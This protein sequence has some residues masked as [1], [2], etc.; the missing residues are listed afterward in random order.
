M[1]TRA[2]AS[3]KLTPSKAKARAKA[4]TPARTKKTAKTKAKAKAPGKPSAPA[5][6]KATKATSAPA[7]RQTTTKAP[8]KAKA[9]ASPAK[10][11]PVAIAAAPTIAPKSVSKAKPTATAAK[12]G[13]SSAY[14][15]LLRAINVGG[16]GKLAMSDLRAM[17]EACGFSDVATYIQSGNVV[18]RS[19]RSAAEVKQLL[20]AALEQKLGKPYGA[21]IRDAA[22]MASLATAPPFPHAAPNQLLVM[23]FDVPPAQADVDKVLAPGGEELELRGREL[24]VHFPMGAGESKLK[25]P[26]AKLATARNLNTVR[27]LVQMSAAL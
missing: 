10:Q 7:K 15:A 9:P 26:F 16:T 20:E 3:A 21:I 14:V 22:E 27:M 8:S 18:F 2:N 13:G 25:L 17:C 1:P 11:P 23:F 24:Y 4:Q 6:T 12:S 19:D 5:K